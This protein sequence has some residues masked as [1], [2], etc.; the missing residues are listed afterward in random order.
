LTPDDNSNIPLYPCVGLRTPGEE[1]EANFGSQPFVF[2]IMT[3]L[4]VR[5]QGDQPV[6][7]T[8]PCPRAAALPLPFACPFI[9][10]TD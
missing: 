1:V 5:L 2:D 6:A 10:N 9:E 4:E 7:D 3:V 8:L